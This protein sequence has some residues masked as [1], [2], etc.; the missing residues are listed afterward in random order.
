MVVDRTRNAASDERSLR[1]RRRAH[2]RKISPKLSVLR[3]DSHDCAF[4]EAQRSV[5]RSVKTPACTH[6][7][8]RPSDH[9][10]VVVLGPM[11]QRRRR[12][13]TKGLMCELSERVSD[14]DTR[15]RESVRHR[16]LIIEEGRIGLSSP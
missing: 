7:Y 11:Q 15:H 3:S 16:H 6:L 5:K 2:E 12:R 13:R 14:T 8:L 9:M 10:S 4:Q 1:K